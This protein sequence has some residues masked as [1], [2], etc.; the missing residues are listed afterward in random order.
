MWNLI[1]Q[2]GEVLAPTVKSPLEDMTKHWKEVRCF[3]IDQEDDVDYADIPLHLQ[4]I[5]RTLLEE[6]DSIQDPGETG[7]CLE[8]F[9]H[10]RI[11]ETL[12]TLGERDCPPGMRRLILSTVPTLLQ[13]MQQPLLPHMSIH[14]PLCQLVSSVPNIPDEEMSETVGFLKTIVSTLIKEPSLSGFFFV[15]PE[16]QASIFVP[17]QSAQSLLARDSLSLDLRRTLQRHVIL[18][19]V[20]L[21]ASSPEVLQYLVA[22]SNLHE[23]LV[24]SL[25]NYYRLLPSAVD[26]SANVSPQVYM[27]LRYVHS[28]LQAISC[29]VERGPTE[30]ASPLLD[31]LH[32]NFIDTVLL[33]TLL[34]A[35]PVNQTAATVYLR[36]IIAPPPVIEGDPPRLLGPK[37]L[38]L[39]LNGILGKERTDAETADG[40]QK[41]L[42]SGDKAYELRSHLLLR[43]EASGAP[44]LQLATL[45]LVDTLI[46]LNDERVMNDL[47]FRS[48]P[49]IP[50][51][52]TSTT[53]TTTITA[54]PLA[55]ASDPVEESD[56]ADLATQAAIGFLL[57]LFGGV[58]RGGEMMLQGRTNDFEAYLTDAQQSLVACQHAC[59][60]WKMV[61]NPS[62]TP[63]TPFFGPVLT[64]L[65]ALLRTLLDSSLDFNLVLSGIL[66]RLSLYPHPALR[67]WLFL[68]SSA[69]TPSSSDASTT[70]VS[71]VVRGPLFESLRTLSDAILARGQTMP[72]FDGAVTATRLA[73]ATEMG[74]EGSTTTTTAAASFDEATLQFLQAVIVLREFALEL[75]S[76]LQANVM[77]SDWSATAPAQATPL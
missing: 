17:L 23:Q 38:N 52:N 48:L 21:A 58:G 15:Y 33:P 47:F 6:E 26:A 1:S 76:I 35:D 13:N 46:G 62:A 74:K 10:H 2:V 51:D 65:F 25:L 30:F 56:R 29:C 14:A 22:Q 54:H 57:T 69:V 53:T 18:P 4:E 37:I 27:S 16:N 5:V 39:I 34:H 75:S 77:L 28:V 36:E 67:H 63:D 20:L 72:D 40:V 68:H 19:C 45:R 7:P 42:E 61:T 70:A 60:G 24:N 11:L 73:L 49:S 64:R 66:S 9:L 41:D 32:R 43:L 3:Y 31:L 12:C 55:P 50:S 59:D 44:D 71:P 8:Y